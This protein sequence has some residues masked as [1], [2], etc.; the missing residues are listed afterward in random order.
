MLYPEFGAVCAVIVT[1]NIGEAFYINFAATCPQVD[2]S[3]IIDNGSSDDTLAVLERIK[4]ENPD[5][6]EILHNPENGLA[7]AQNMGIRRAQEL[8]HG[9]VLLL[10]HDSRPSERMVDVMQS[11]FKSLSAAIKKTTLILAANPFDINRNSAL[12][13]VKKRQNLIPLTYQPADEA[14]PYE[15]LWHAFASGSLLCLHHINAAGLMDESLFIDSVDVEYGIRANLRGFSILLIPSAILN[16]SLGQ[17]NR[18]VLSQQITNHSAWR[19][20]YI[21]R[22][23]VLLFK[24]YVFKA[25]AVVSIDMLRA[26]GGL[27]KIMLFEQNRTEK[28]KS[29][30]LGLWHGLRGVTGKKP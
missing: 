4:A 9:W 21:Y 8:G 17:I 7:K 10:D 19:R 24:H 26:I 29:A 28:L 18:V 15:E 2:L 12:Y 27:A 20:Y 25:P 11:T 6:V 3:I 5:R 30:L 23:R 1:Y 16:H 14:K 22:N 13:C